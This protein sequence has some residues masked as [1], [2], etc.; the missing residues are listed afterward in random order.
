[1]KFRGLVHIGLITI[2]LFSLGLWAEEESPQRKTFRIPEINSDIEIDGV[3]DEGAWEKALSFPVNIE[4]M[5]GESVEAPVKTECLLMYDKQNLYVGFLAYDPE[6]EK[7]RSYLSDRD[8]AWADDFV[9]IILDT[10]N[11]ENR[12]FAFFVNPL[13]IQGDEIY[14]RGG[15]YEDDSWDAIWDSAGKIA[16]FGYSV[17]IAIPFRSLQFQPSEEEQVW[18][19][20]PVRNYP[21]SRRH[22][23]S[24]FKHNRNEQCLLCQF[25]KLVGF[26]K[27]TPGHNIELDPT[28]TG[29]RTDERQDFPAG[30]MKERDSN[31]DFGIS[32]QW[33]FTNNLT[34]SAALNPDFSHVEADVAQLEINKRFALYYPEK[35]PFFLEGNDFFETSLEAIY[36][37]S[38]ADPDWGAKVSGKEGKNAIGIFSS[39][40]RIT[41]LI[42]PGAEESRSTS[43][44]QVSYANVLRYRRDVGTASTVGVLVTDREGDDYHN[45]VIGVD[46]L[47]RFSKSDSLTFQLMGSQTDYPEEVAQD[48]GQD[49]DAFRGY[50]AYLD[51]RREKRSYGLSASLIDCSPDFRADLG[52]M[53]QVDYRRYNTGAW[54]TYW[55][56]EKEF[57]SRIEV[58]LDFTQTDDHDGNLLDR[59]WE[60]EF[61]FD[62]PLQSFFVWEANKRKRIYRSVS[63]SQV[64]N[65][66]YFSIRPSGFLNA[67]IWAGYGDEIDYENVRAGKELAFE[68][69]ITLKCGKHINLNVSHSFSRLNV[70]GKRLFTANLT[71][72][73]LIYHFNSRAFLRAILQYRD[74][75]RNQDVYLSPVDPESNR[76]FSQ[77]LFSYKINPRT[78]LFIG[79]SD[80]Y[81]GFQDVDLTQSNR[82]FF[83]K[84]GYAF[85]L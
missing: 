19:F 20:A 62:G 84:I 70:E 85:S 27:V 26:K 79:Y 21:R 17:E 69:D 61:D 78:V 65:F 55:G 45:R 53:P 51:L 30:K 66:A 7:I 48:F 3:L 10:F 46:G 14:S 33:G 54:Y 9:G 80:N 4:I 76:L 82:T 22:Q 44:D 72:M 57:F 31:L 34:L 81:Y 68:P 60:F 47:F 43:L 64:Y 40:D 74:I 29:I 6:S 23:I 73:R 25:P 38:V 59:E 56:K 32:G 5:P 71:Q 16:D 15:S 42:F 39:Q 52:F 18:G 58:S 41:N 50:A 35:R 75:E 11:D 49:L 24:N 77:F 67:G 13:G 37:R 28:M 8:S 36:T 2:F 63:F 83:L 12:G 1:M